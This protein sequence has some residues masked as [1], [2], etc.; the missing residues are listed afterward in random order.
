[1]H[2]CERSAIFFS[3]IWVS[4]NNNCCRF[5]LILTGVHGPIRI[6]SKLPSN[7]MKRKRSV[8]HISG[9]RSLYIYTHVC[10]THRDHMH[11]YF[12]SVQIFTYILTYYYVHQYIHTFI[13]TYVRTYIEKCIY[14][15]IHVDA[16]MCRY[17]YVHPC[18]KLASHVQLFL[19]CS[20]RKSHRGIFHQESFTRRPRGGPEQRGVATA[21]KVL[22]DYGISRSCG[23]IQTPS[24]QVPVLKHVLYINCMYR[25]YTTNVLHVPMCIYIYTYIYIYI[26]T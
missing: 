9:Q 11:H 4:C 18:M 19:A 8:K 26:Y 12:L 20:A 13:H 25:K 2:S 1:M 21:R 15:N 6:L 14:N 7:W 5:Y 17:L 16:Y 22:L 24:V 10:I 23:M 3:M